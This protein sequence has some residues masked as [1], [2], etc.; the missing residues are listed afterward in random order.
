[1][2]NYTKA[3]LT[4]IALCIGPEANADS[5]E[6]V[7]GRY[8]SELE[9]DA[10]VVGSAWIDKQNFE[11]FVDYYPTITDETKLQKMTVQGEQI[12]K[13][14]KASELAVEQREF[15]IMSSKEYKSTLEHL[16]S[17]WALICNK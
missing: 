1:M 16:L 11:A 14:F 17:K 3:V 4:L 13:K 5:F 7:K 9:K 2:D 15:S 8:C 10:A 6:A 12:H